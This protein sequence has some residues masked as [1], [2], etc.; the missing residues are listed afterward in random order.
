[1]FGSDEAHG[2]SAR[3][4][5]PSGQNAGDC[6]ASEKGDRTSTRVRPRS[7][8]R[9]GAAD[10]PS[11]TDRLVH[12]RR[13]RGLHRESEGRA[14]PNGTVVDLDFGSKPVALHWS[15]APAIVEEI[16]SAGVEVASCVK[17]AFY[18][19]FEGSP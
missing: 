17:R 2:E 5:L 9:P 19:F 14:D 8:S 12:G 16:F 13:L 7:S 4:P 18:T 10:G 6:S 3:L 1:M 11:S 15:S